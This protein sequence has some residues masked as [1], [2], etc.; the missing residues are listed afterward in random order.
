MSKKTHTVL[1]LV[2][3]LGMVTAVPAVSSAAETTPFQLDA[4]IGYGSGP[5]DFDAGFGFNF[6]GGY[7]LN[8][9]DPNL[10]ARMEIGYFTFDRDLAGVSLDYTRMPFAFG[11][12]YYL[13]V[14][15][16]LK[17]FGQAAVE[18]SVDEFETA[19]VFGKSSESEVNFG[20]TPAVGLD[21]EISRELSLF[22]TASMHVIS[23]NY[24]SMQFGAAYHF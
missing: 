5:G 19:T 22:T 6:G 9:I 16:R 21:F 20:I 18:L 8:S 12:R 1:V 24:F 14:A 7:M 13:P 2:L 10:Q 17:L 15:E 4:S 23:D 3:L 11:A